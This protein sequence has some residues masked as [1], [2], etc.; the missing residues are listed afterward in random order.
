VSTDTPSQ[1]T[2]PLGELRALLD[3]AN[4]A[5]WTAMHDEGHLSAVWFTQG[6]CYSDIEPADADLI[7][8]ARN[9]LPAMLEALAAAREELAATRRAKRENDERFMLE[10]DAAR[11]EAEK[12]RAEAAQAIGTLSQIL[13]LTAWEDGEQRE[14]VPVA[15]ILDVL[16][17]R[18]TADATPAAA[19]QA[20]EPPCICFESKHLDL[21]SDILSRDGEGDYAHGVLVEWQDA[22][23]R[24]NA[25]KATGGVV[26]GTP[27][28]VGETGCEMPPALMRKPAEASDGEQAATTHS[29]AV[30]YDGDTLWLECDPCHEL[31]PNGDWLISSIEAGTTWDEIT[32]HVADHEAAA[33]VPG[34]ATGDATGGD[35]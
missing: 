12:L 21:L 6:A 13:D 25:D 35:R 14:D 26:T 24:L 27:Y 9:Q 5:P 23:D 1:P 29:Y 17:A 19:P 8:A 16:T 2:P 11:A 15:E 33:A 20:A 31:N 32:K 18:T 28:L 3:A 4:P 30:S 22:I 10:R 7:A 34:D